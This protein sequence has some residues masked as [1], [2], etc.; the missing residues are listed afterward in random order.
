M[1]LKTRF[2]SDS[3]VALITSMAL[4]TFLVTVAAA[5]AALST[6]NL[7]SMVRSDQWMQA[8]YL[9][10][11]GAQAGNVMLRTDGSAGESTTLYETIG[12]ETATVDVEPLS[13]SQ[14]RIQSTGTIGAEQV[15]VE[16]HV[17]FIL[18]SLLDGGLQINVSNGVEVQGDRVAVWMGDDSTISGMDHSSTG[19]QLSDQSAA[20]YGVA[21]N[22]VP[23]ETGVDLEIDILSR[24]TAVAEGEPDRI[25]NQADNISAILQNLRGTAQAEADLYVTGTT[26]L[27]S[28]ATGSYGTAEDPAL[29]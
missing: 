17:E 9:A 29:V 7:R 8:F 21:L 3:G 23:G 26:R 4:V 15:S 12:G 27:D 13:S 1:C 11:S 19:T 6:N 5:L 14:C 10:D 16:M 22:P 2:P 20:V 18:S 24:D 25:T 28:S